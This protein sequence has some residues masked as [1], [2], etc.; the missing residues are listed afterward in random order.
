LIIPFK[1]EKHLFEE[2]DFIFLKLND[3]TSY[4][5]PPDSLYQ[6]ITL[7]INKL[8]KGFNKLKFG[9]VIK[10]DGTE[11]FE[12]FYGTSINYLNKE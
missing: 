4:T 12:Y 1:I 6:I 2:V 8:N 7:N 9:Y 5:Q 10:E 3:T 11:E